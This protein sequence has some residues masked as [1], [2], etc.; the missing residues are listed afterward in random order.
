MEK[1][2]QFLLSGKGSSLPVIVAV[3]G[4]S[5]ILSDKITSSGYETRNRFEAN[6]LCIARLTHNQWSA[7]HMYIYNEELKRINGEPVPNV[8]NIIEVVDGKL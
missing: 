1:I 8:D 2:L 6:E 7:T 3:V 5:W 4:S